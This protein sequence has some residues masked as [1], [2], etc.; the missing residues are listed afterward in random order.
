MRRRTRASSQGTPD[1]TDDAERLVWYVAYG[2]NLL[3]SRIECYL[4]GGQPV[5]ARRTYQGCR[6]KRPAIASRRWDLP[7]TV[8][9]AGASTT[10]G[11]P[12]SGV[13]FYD[14]TTSGP[15]VGRG[16][17]LRLEQVI[18]IVTQE[19]GQDTGKFDEPLTRLLSGTSVEGGIP[20]LG[21]YDRLIRLDSV[22]EHP[23]WTLTSGAPARDLGLNAPSDTYRAAISAGL[24]ETTGWDGAKVDAYLESLPGVNA[25]RSPLL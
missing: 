5:G 4:H 12:A 6:D 14:P 20:A 11:T 9:L 24:K 2:S 17:L 21:A 7:G 19:N 3:T 23:A 16:W 10:W 13:A 18:D 8:C 1:V 15:A 25:A 22:D